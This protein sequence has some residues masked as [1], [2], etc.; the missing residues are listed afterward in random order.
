METT[1]IFEVGGGSRTRER[2]DLA[3]LPA[4]WLAAAGLALGLTRLRSF[5]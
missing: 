3:L 2:F 5:P 1:R 4:F